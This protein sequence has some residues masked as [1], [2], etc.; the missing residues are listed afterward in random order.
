MVEEN[1]TVDQQTA[2]LRVENLERREAMRQQAEEMEP[3][4]SETTAEAPTPSPTPETE[5]TEPEQPE[6]PG[7]PNIT[8]VPLASEGDPRI[9]QDALNPNRLV[10]AVNRLVYGDTMIAEA[11]AAKQSGMVSM[12]ALSDQIVPTPEVQMMMSET[13][14]SA[15]TVGLYLLAKNDPELM[16]QIRP[17]IGA[18]GTAKLGV[19]YREHFGQTTVREPTVG[20]FTSIFTDMS[21]LVTEGDVVEGALAGVA[22]VTKQ[23][24][25]GA[26]VLGG[27]DNLMMNLLGNSNPLA[28]ALTTGANPLG[29]MRRRMSA[30]YSAQQVTYL[31]DTF[32]IQVVSDEYFEYQRQVAE[33]DR[34]ND[35]VLID[36][37]ARTEEQLLERIDS[38]SGNLVAGLTEWGVSYAVLPAKVINATKTFG[39]IANGVLKGAAVDNF[40]YD[41]DEG[42]LTTM[43]K[44]L[45][46][47]DPET[48]NAVI[49]LL[50][51]DVGESELEQRLAVVLEGA[52][53]GATAEA[54]VAGAVVGIRKF[55]AGKSP[56]EVAKAIDG[57][58]TDVANNAE[59]SNTKTMDELDEL[60]DETY[61]DVPD[62]AI[63]PLRDVEVS[64]KIL[65]NELLPLNAVDDASR[66][67]LYRYYKQGR[68][69]DLE[70]P[71]DT[72]MNLLNELAGFNLR[73]SVL[74]GDIDEIMGN[75]TKRLKAAFGKTT[76]VKGKKAIAVMAKQVMAR[77]GEKFLS[78]DL[79]QSLKTD[80]SEWSDQLSAN[81][82]AAAMVQDVLNEQLS[83]V[84]AE[85]AQFKQ[86]VPVKSSVFPHAKDYDDL[87][88]IH[89]ELIA[90]KGVMRLGS[91]KIMNQS[92]N[93]MR[94]SQFLFDVEKNLEYQRA[95]IAWKRSRGI[96]NEDQQFELMHQAIERAKTMKNSSAVINEIIEASSI[97]KGL[98]KWLRITNANL[99]TG[100]TT[101]LVMLVSNISR[102]ASEGLYKAAEAGV[103]G[104]R[105]VFTKDAAT[106]A[107]AF[108]NSSM[109]IR[110][111]ALWYM[112]FPRLFPE[113][114]KGF[115]RYWRSG[116]SEFN[117]RT[118]V[119][120]DQSFAGKSLS[121]I[122]Q[123]DEG[124]KLLTKSEVVYRWIGAVDE[125]FKELV[126]QSDQAARYAT[127]EFGPVNGKRWDQI[128]QEDITAA[129]KDS[130]DVIQGSNGRLSD[131]NSV[132]RAKEAMFQFDPVKGSLRHGVQKFLVNPN[133]KFALVLRMIGMRFVST[134]FAVMEKRF[135]DILAPVILAADGV[136]K[137]TGNPKAGASFRV[138]A[139]KFADDLASDDITIRSR[140]RA[141]LAANS[142]AASAGLFL[143]ISGQHTV[144]LDPS[145][146]HYLKMR[147]STGDGKARYV[148]V[149][150]GESIANATI[151]YMAFA[152]LI[153][154][155]VD[156][157]NQLEMFDSV[158]AIM[159]LSL[160]ETLE[161][162]SLATA[163]ESIDVISDPSATTVQK[164]LINQVT[165]FNPLGWWQRKVLNAA[166]SMD[167][168]GFDGRPV[169][170]FEQLSRAVP[171]FR[172][173]SDGVKNRQRNALGEKTLP[174]EGVLRF[175]TPEVGDDLIDRELLAIQ[176][177]TGEDFV[178]VQLSR[179]RVDY[180]KESFRPGQ[181]VYDRAQDLIA[182]G[183]IKILGLT[184]REALDR[185][186]RSDNYRKSYKAHI[187]DLRDNPR[188]SNGILRATLEELKD[189]RVVSV[190]KILDEYREK[191]INE[192]LRLMETSDLQD[193][194]DE[195][196]SRRRDPDTVY[197]I[198]NEN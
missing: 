78:A 49:D 118:F 43:L 12:S 195:R 147:V 128:T 96:I 75:V 111:A 19:A 76:E 36:S 152:D 151:M 198:F 183:E 104:I 165:P 6:A 90:K 53:L 99:L 132:E 93:A 50:S 82:T 95:K 173:L 157:T 42:N 168:D 39:L 180:M 71:A 38:V 60:I 16:D 13:G 124:L 114:L 164:F 77:H 58:L 197:R 54:L 66:D 98:E 123:M 184:L 30:E 8:A 34:T 67:N 28:F 55:R 97:P 130:P 47:I 167:D 155:G 143:Y 87:V 120:E 121:E 65:F 40:V 7:S 105:G 83:Q 146:P 109:K 106:R 61:A 166:R 26:R 59:V 33:R 113:A 62:E 72:N 153:S 91:S 102:M 145:S 131:I 2:R 160:S 133:N 45:G 119:D 127:G 170:F 191:A 110:Q 150:D 64:D 103:E 108:S 179:D 149:M 56:E 125:A 156:P 73:Q 196:D 63:A 137:L 182:D 159:A 22:G 141:V 189:P 178:R 116:Q 44:D 194:A 35:Q 154:K 94:T 115:R 161:K 148:N 32:G 80:V 69:N 188:T 31:Q 162:S 163:M 172:P 134:P 9:I 1:L 190:R 142:L 81:L 27:V 68:M 169:T 185:L 17:K 79:Q 171:V 192:T 177:E 126:V 174:A 85:L 46:V 29:V 70:G 14:E 101:Q 139:G 187:E 107:E 3:P 144:N 136:G 84:L 135:T 138:V 140:A 88:I 51:A 5:T 4:Q 41:D 158:V 21:K 92:A 20:V 15:Q 100:I 181:S 186:F 122:S 112:N 52:L 176:T 175:V 117:T 74:T 10:R 129:L 18:I 193:I 23:T 48:Q 89:D 37:I 24:A 86:G 57:K 25:E 11:L